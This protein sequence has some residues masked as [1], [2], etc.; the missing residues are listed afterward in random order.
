MPHIRWNE[1]RSACENARRKLPEYVSSYFAYV[2]EVLAGDPPP[3]EL[4][5][6]RLATKRLRY[7]LELFRP[8]Y[9]RGLEA[10]IKILRKVQQRLGDVNDA[11]AA[12]DLLAKKLGRS[13]LRE[14][15]R[16]FL[17][18]RAEKE[19]RE[20]QREWKRLFEAPGREQWWTEYLSGPKKRASKSMRRPAGLAR[21]LH[22]KGH[23]AATP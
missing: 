8:C 4:H 11:V 13:D 10:R 2:R 18:D 17:Q 14:R 19:A 5:Q 1:R 21:A 23:G 12:W 22:R 15:T 6:L 3:R 20:F 16:N 7:T 9:G